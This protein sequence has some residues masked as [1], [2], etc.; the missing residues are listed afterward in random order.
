MGHVYA[1]R[2]S[3]SSIGTVS[4]GRRNWASA[5]GIVLVSL[6]SVRVECNGWLWSVVEGRVAVRAEVLGIDGNAKSSGNGASLALGGTFADE[7]TSASA[8]CACEVEE[9]WLIIRANV[10]AGSSA[11]VWDRAAF[12][13]SRAAGASAALEP[14]ETEVLIP[15]LSTEAMASGETCVDD[16]PSFVPTVSEPSGGT[17]AAEPSALRACQEYGILVTYLGALLPSAFPC[18]S[19][20][21][22]CQRREGSTGVSCR[23]SESLE[24]RVVQ[25][26]FGL[27]KWRGSFLS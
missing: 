27:G 2:G 9:C 14:C 23:R 16:E 7:G 10:T 5:F 21:C 1:A 13:E 20:F 6:C 4:T 25:R 11:S 17:S 3:T 12:S 22:Y 15:E 19:R 18:G 26:C 24:Q 8:L